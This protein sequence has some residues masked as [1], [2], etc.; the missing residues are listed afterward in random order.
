MVLSGSVGGPLVRLLLAFLALFR[1][2]GGFVACFLLNFVRFFG[3]LPLLGSFGGSVVGLLG[4]LV[5]FWWLCCVPFLGSFSLLTLFGDCVDCLLL[6]Y[7]KLSNDCHKS[8][9]GDRRQE[10][11][12]KKFYTGGKR[13]WGASPQRRNTQ[14]GI[15]T[16]W[17]KNG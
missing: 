13:N 16:A 10:T 8:D 7:T 17:N 4:L 11:S 3:F 15:E 9:T 2:F 14:L 6:S 1:S 12:R 5:L